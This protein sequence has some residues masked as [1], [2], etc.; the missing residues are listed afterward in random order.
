MNYFKIIGLA[1]I[2][3]GSPLSSVA[4]SQEASF[5]N[6]RYSP[7]AKSKKVLGVPVTGP[8]RFCGQLRWSFEEQGINPISFRQLGAYA[9]GQELPEQLTEENC[10]ADQL[11]A[12]IHDPIISNNPPGIVQ[13]P[14][15]RLQNIPL[16]DVPKIAGILQGGTTGLRTEL[17]KAPQI[18]ANPF[19]VYASESSS[20]ITLGKWASAKGVLKYRCQAD[21]SAIV[22]ASFSNLIGNGVYSMWA[23]FK[24]TLPN[25]ITADLPVPFGGVPNALVPNQNGR[26]KFERKIPF[27]PNDETSDGSLLLWV[28]LAYHSDS[29]LYAGVPDAADLNATFID[30]NGIGYE[31]TLSLMVHHEQLAFPINFTSVIQE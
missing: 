12:T 31:S 7:N 25:G 11:L 21:G 17:E 26:A 16:R 13:V 6:W 29:S 2:I 30:K 15:V 22:K 24:T 8:N 9:P 20:D 4:N 10:T 1:S 23:I 3:S 18:P 28:A 5:D 19:P 27:C 14:D